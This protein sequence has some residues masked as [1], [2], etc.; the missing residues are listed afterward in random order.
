MSSEELKIIIKCI[1]HG[2]SSMFRA[3]AWKWMK[4]T[5]DDNNFTWLQVIGIVFWNDYRSHKHWQRNE[6]W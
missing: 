1:L 5:K 6:D 2:I 4:E 3:S